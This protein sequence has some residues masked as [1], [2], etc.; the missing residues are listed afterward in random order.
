MTLAPGITLVAT[1]LGNIADASDRLRGALIDADI[2]AAE[3][4]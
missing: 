3:D 2:I 1:P 4:T